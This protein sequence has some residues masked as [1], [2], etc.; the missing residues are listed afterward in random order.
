MKAPNKLNE[1][2]NENNDEMKKL[3]QIN[4]NRLRC[5][6]KVI[7]LHPTQG[8]VKAEAQSD[9]SRVCVRYCG[10]S[11]GMVLWSLVLV[12]GAMVLR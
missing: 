10:A 9:W 6:R 3:Q 11:G 12:F 4:I 8:R 5:D 2:T 1:K 7:V